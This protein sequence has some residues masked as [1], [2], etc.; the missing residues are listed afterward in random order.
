M[1]YLY[2]KKH[3]CLIN[4]NPQKM[5]T[6]IVFISVICLAIEARAQGDEKMMYESVKQQCSGLPLTK[7]AR[8]SVTRFSVTT[9][10]GDRATRANANANN[11]LKALSLLSGNKGDAP[12]ADIIPPTLGDNMTT[13]LTNALQGVNCFRV[14]ESLKNNDDLT[15]EINAG[16][17]ALSSKKAPKAGK[18]LG[19]QIV[20][21]GEVIEYSVKEKGLNVVGVGTGKKFVKIGFN[22]K[23]IN[24]ET[25]DIIT[26][27]VFRVQSKTGNHVSVLGLVSTADND[28]AVAAVMEDG[29]IYATEYLSHVRDS[30]NI[31]SDNIPGTGNG[32]G[33]GNEVEITL[34][35]ATFGSFNALANIISGTTGYQSME[36]SF[37]SGVGSFT[38]TSSGKPDNFLDDLTKKLGLKY[39][40]TGIDAGKMELK[41]K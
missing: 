20:V 23:L 3:S 32:S 15:Q 22:L 28:P 12:R 35:N 4:Q 7:R 17:T 25:R 27:K 18:Q 16:T 37:S 41:A 39:E 38:V 10:T 2:S 26:S 14:L 34:K 40:V 29:V 36:K 13:M 31:T 1:I 30:L 5:K 9:S 33:G 21:T 19:A 11:R 8:V 6:I 24:P